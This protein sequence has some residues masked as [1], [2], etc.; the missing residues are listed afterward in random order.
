MEDIAI[1]YLFI[2]IRAVMGLRGTI[3]LVAALFAAGHIPTM[4]TEGYSFTELGGLLLDASLG[5]GVLYAVQKS[6]DILWFWCIHF[7]MDM[8]QFYAVP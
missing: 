1:A 4:I 2:R 8:M 5:V 3:F 6:S 7:A